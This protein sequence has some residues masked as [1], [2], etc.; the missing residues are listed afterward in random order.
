VPTVRRPNLDSAEWA[1]LNEAFARIAARSG[2]RSLAAHDLE[3]KLISGDLPSAARQVLHNGGEERQQLQP[4]F[5][6]AGMLLDRT[7]EP[8]R[9]GPD[10]GVQVRLQ[11]PITGSWYFFVRRAA[12]D[13]LYPEA[14]ATHASPKPPRRRTGPVFKHDW[15]TIDGEIARRCHDKSGRL[16]IPKDENKLAEAVGDWLAD[17]GRNVPSPSDL[18]EAVKLVLAALRRAR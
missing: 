15:H 1:P 3:R 10:P 17:E 9:V 11:G 14:P 8:P 18:R 4:A 5:W 16:S 6:H 12:L 2:S 7:W 13:Q